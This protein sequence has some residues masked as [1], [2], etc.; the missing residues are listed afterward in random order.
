MI[1]GLQAETIEICFYITFCGV[2]KR[3]FHLEK[4]KQLSF[5]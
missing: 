4:T 2:G 3:A 5:I 1:I